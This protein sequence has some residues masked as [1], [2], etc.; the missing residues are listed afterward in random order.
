MTRRA[1]TSWLGW[2]IVQ[3]IV[4]AGARRSCTLLLEARN[5]PGRRA[6][7]PIQR[8]DAVGAKKDL[9]DVPR[10]CKDVAGKAAAT[11]PT[12]ANGA[13]SSG[14]RC[15]TTAGLADRDGQ[16]SLVVAANCCARMDTFLVMP[17]SARVGGRVEFSIGTPL[18]PMPRDPDCFGMTRSISPSL[19]SAC[20]RSDFARRI[21][22]C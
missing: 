22:S 16:N 8:D 13:E 6:R 3:N 5:E 21:T 7:R 15:G 14:R 19:R 17:M 4:R 2:W 9:A 1:A 20:R 11:S 12:C 18:V 10:V